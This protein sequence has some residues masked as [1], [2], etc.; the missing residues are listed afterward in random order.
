MDTTHSYPSPYTMECPVCYCAVANC[1]LVCGHGLCRDCATSWYKKSDEP[2]CPMCREPMYFKGMKKLKGDM[3]EDRFEEHCTELFTAAAEDIFED[4][5]EEMLELRKADVSPE[6]YDMVL[7]DGFD[8]LMEDLKDAEK[9]I[10]VMREQGWDIDDM[11]CVLEGWGLQYRDKINWDWV[12]EPTKDQ[13]PDIRWRVPQSIL[14]S[15]KL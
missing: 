1:K 13:V 4:W 14:I 15:C 6:V 12:N 10:Q 5:E 11:R 2:N 3:E 9:K 8:L 7:A